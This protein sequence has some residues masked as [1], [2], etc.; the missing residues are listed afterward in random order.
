MIQKPAHFL[1]LALAFALAIL[2]PALAFAEPAPAPLTNGQFVAFWSIVCFL[3]LI[4]PLLLGAL[5]GRLF[6]GS[7]WRRPAFFVTALL[8]AVPL[9]VLGVF[10]SL[11]V[12]MAFAGRTM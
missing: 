2:T 12:L 8:I 7:G 1:A 4:G 11:F 9:A 10:A 3:V 5:A 6:F